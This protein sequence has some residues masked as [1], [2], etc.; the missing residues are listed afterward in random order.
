MKIIRNI[1][2][3]YRELITQDFDNLVKNETFFLNDKKFNYDYLL[4]IIR[5]ELNKQKI[6]KNWTNYYG[7][8]MIYREKRNLVLFYFNGKSHTIVQSPN[9][10]FIDKYVELIDSDIN[11]SL[12]K[13]K[14]ICEILREKDLCNEVIEIIVKYIEW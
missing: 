1:I 8:D 11:S 5:V 4:D 7:E 6:K 14:T 12:N 2:K 10:N 13:C 3:K 9:Y